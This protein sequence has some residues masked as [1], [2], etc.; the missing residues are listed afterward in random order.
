MWKGGTQLLLPSVVLKIQV[1]HQCGKKGHLEVVCRS[2]P[3]GNSQPQQKHGHPRHVRQV[4]EEDDET[5]EEL[6]LYR[7]G[8]RTDTQPLKVSVCIDKQ[9]VATDGAG[10]RCCSVPDG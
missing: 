1:C 6:K 10:H 8:S 4:Q 2:K 7:I 5:D 3:K 9:L